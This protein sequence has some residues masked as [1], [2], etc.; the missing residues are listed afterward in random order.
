MLETIKKKYTLTEIC[1]FLLLAVQVGF[2][3]FINLFYN[4][5]LNDYDAAGAYVHILE[6]YKSHTLFPST[7]GYATTMD[8]DSMVGPAS[9]VFALCKDVFMAQGICNIIVVLAYLFVIREIFATIGADRRA[10]LITMILVI[11]PYSMSIVG[12]WDVMFVGAAANAVRNLIPLLYF[13]ILLDLRQDRRGKLLWIKVAACL[14]LMLLTSISAGYY[15][16]LF[17][18][19]S[20][21]ACDFYLFLK[22]GEPAELLSL[23]W[24]LH[25]MMAVI[26][27]IG[28]RIQSHMGFTS[29]SAEQTIVPAIRFSQNMG[30]WFTGIFELFGALPEEGE[31]ALSDLVG[32]TMALKYGICLFFLGSFLLFLLRFLRQQMIRPHVLYVLFVG[33]IDALAL[34]FLDTTYG[35]LTYEY[36]YHIMPMLFVMM[37]GGFFLNEILT[38]GNETAKRMISLAAI[39]VLTATIGYADSVARIYVDFKDAPDGVNRSSSVLKEIDDFIEENGIETAIIYSDLFGIESRKL[40]AYGDTTDYVYYPISDGAPAYGWGGSS[41]VQLKNGHTGKT[42]MITTS[43]EFDAAPDTIRSVATYLGQAG[44]MD[45][46]LIPEGAFDL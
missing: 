32:R 12:Y 43:V 44:N 35:T 42:A 34:L 40:R 26:C 15:V 27:M 9:L 13:S 14:L 33:I 4:A 8:V 3:S 24:G 16:M 1:L 18:I 6:I 22:K 5:P 30:A 23:R 45:I 37:G 28:L 38:S 29:R 17:G 46:Y 41:R 2:T 36:R 31:V 20:L 10:M 25:I 11:L 19:L 7:Y 21:I 39:V